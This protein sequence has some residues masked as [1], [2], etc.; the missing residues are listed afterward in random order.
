MT[1]KNPV[2]GIHWVY[3]PHYS[4]STIQDRSFVKLDCSC[5]RIKSLMSMPSYFYDIT[6]WQ[7]TPMMYKHQNKM[8]FTILL[9]VWVVLL[10][11]HV[12]IEVF[13][14][15]VHALLIRWH[16]MGSEVSICSQCFIGELLQW[17]ILNLQ[18]IQ[19]GTIF[20]LNHRI[21]NMI[22]EAGVIDIILLASFGKLTAKSLRRH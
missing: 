17:N 11:F 9:S 6:S 22:T 1:K 4:R 18:M 15:S 2:H 5:E 21:L 19:N 12:F 13:S 16:R 3:A 10:N 7:A 8:P 14:I 20:S